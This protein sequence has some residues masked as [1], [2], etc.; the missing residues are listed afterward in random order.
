MDLKVPVSKVISGDDTQRGQGREG[1]ARGDGGGGGTT[2]IS[3]HN[4]KLQ[5][6]SETLHTKTKNH[7]QQFKLLL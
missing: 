5:A 6:D 4:K 1:E 3:Q 2:Q 7:S